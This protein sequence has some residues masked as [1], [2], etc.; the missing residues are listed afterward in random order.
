MFLKIKGLRRQPHELGQRPCDSIITKELDFFF[1]CCGMAEN[2]AIWPN[3]FYC[4]IYVRIVHCKISIDIIDNG[5][6]R[7]FYSF[8]TPAFHI[9]TLQYQYQQSAPLPQ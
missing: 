9:I 8:L 6:S 1:A 3:C 5:L 2:L 7:F 4:V